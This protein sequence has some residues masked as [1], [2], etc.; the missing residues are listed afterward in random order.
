MRTSLNFRILLDWQEGRLAPAEAERVA[1]QLVTPTDEELQTLDWLRRFSA[2]A[3]RIRF[4]RPGVACARRLRSLMT[5]APAQARPGWITLIARLVSGPGMLSGPVAGFRGES[6]LAP[7]VFTA[8]AL[9]VTVDLLPGD[10]PEQ[11]HLAGQITGMQPDQ[12]RDDHIMVWVH[13]SRPAGVTRQAEVDGYG[14]F[15][16][17]DLHPGHY[18]LVIFGRSFEL[19]LPSIEVG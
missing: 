1:G 4:A 12:I 17:S 3:E 11:V 19:L 13:G 10:Q 2:A 5:E 14:E 7:F 8:E 18:D 16:I 6:G 15:L 9:T